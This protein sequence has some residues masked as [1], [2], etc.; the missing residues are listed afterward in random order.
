M[1]I[2]GYYIKGISKRFWVILVAGAFLLFLLIS[3]WPKAADPDADWLSGQDVASLADELIIKDQITPAELEQ[4]IG[5][6]QNNE[7][8]NAL[9]DP[10]PALN[11]YASLGTPYRLRVFVP[12]GNTE[13]PTDEGKSLQEERRSLFSEEF[14]EYGWSFSPAIIFGEDGITETAIIDQGG[15]ELDTTALSDAGMEAFVPGED[16]LLGEGDVVLGIKDPL[17]PGLYDVDGVLIGMSNILTAETAREPYLS[18]PS[19]V[20]LV[21]RY[22]PITPAE[23]IAPASEI[24]E[25]GINYSVGNLYRLRLDQ[26]EWPGGS[27]PARLCLQVRNISNRRLDVWGGASL[28]N[29]KVDD[30]TF[31]D[32]D[33]TGTVFASEQFESGTEVSGYVTLG[34]SEGSPAELSGGTAGKDI[35]LEIPTLRST[36]GDSGSA[37]AIIQI[38]DNPQT[39]QES[40]LTVDVPGLDSEDVVPPLEPGSLCSG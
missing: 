1:R 21:T 35:Q 25:L 3:M 18:N 16:G 34:D 14:D 22:V 7:C 15:D 36:S 24:I 31:S 13:T 10:A 40:L 27:Q 28:I 33:G 32:L 8:I 9:R 11:D 20:L 38:T 6:G 2:G 12:D 26:L 37:E 17:G 29:L 19:P 30:A 23:V 39:G 5:C 4:R